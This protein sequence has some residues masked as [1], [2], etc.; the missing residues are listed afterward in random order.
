M[1]VDGQSAEVGSNPIT[2]TIFLKGIKMKD[3]LFDM[4]T[5]FLILLMPFIGMLRIE[6]V[7][8]YALIL[9]VGA[10]VTFCILRIFNRPIN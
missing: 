4:M 2:H 9:F 8:K 6:S 1:G 10:L 5:G 3:S 7:Y